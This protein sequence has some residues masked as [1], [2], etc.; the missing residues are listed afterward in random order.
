[1][2]RRAYHLVVFGATGFTGTLMAEYLAKKAPAG[3]RWAMAGRA[4]SKVWCVWGGGWVA[5]RW[6]A[7]PSTR[8][9]AAVVRPC[10]CSAWSPNCYRAA[11]RATGTRP[12]H[13]R[14]AW[15]P[16]PLLCTAAACPA[17]PAGS[18]HRGGRAGGGRGGSGL[19]DHSGGIHS[20]VRAR[21]WRW[22]LLVG[23]GRGWG[24]VG[25]RE[26]FRQAG[27]PSGCSSVTC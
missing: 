16:P 20:G 14:V 3:L 18:G 19:F 24:T 4:E 12:P 27:G 6:L 11:L 13:A 7:A 22:K 17:G 25:D 8:V 2:S 5:L 10:P 26:L 21:V 15:H 9:H 23:R 1:M